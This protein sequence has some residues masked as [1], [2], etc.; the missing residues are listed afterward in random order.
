MKLFS[1]NL[2]HYAARVRIALIVKGLTVEF[3]PPPVGGMEESLRSPEYLALN[4][5]PMGKVPCLVTDDGDVLSESSVIL[6]YL[7]DAYPDPPLMPASAKGRARVRLA[8]RVGEFYV[9][10]PMQVLLFQTNPAR[11]DP[12]LAEANLAK[13]DVGLTWLEQHLDDGPYA[14]GDGFTLAD[15]VLPTMARIV[16]DFARV[17]D[18]PELA[19]NHPKV[20]GYLERVRA[21]PAVAEVFEQM[22]TASATYRTT[23]KMT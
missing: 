21:H 15:C 19:A 8:I 2:S 10:V 12:A 5:N 11:R 20:I 22:A 18:K 23:G 6:E 1:L 7:E 9:A 4:P 13:M 16:P 14:V 3:V 17:F